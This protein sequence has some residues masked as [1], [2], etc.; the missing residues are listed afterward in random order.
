M[1]CV[2][3][4]VMPP[5][6]PRVTST[7]AVLKRPRTLAMVMMCPWFW[8]FIWGRKAF[9]VWDTHTHTHA[10]DYYEATAPL[11]DLWGLKRCSMRRELTLHER[12]RN[13]RIFAGILPTVVWRGSNILTQFVFTR[14]V[15]H[16]AQWPALC[17]CRCWKTG[18]KWWLSKRQSPSVLPDSRDGM[19][20]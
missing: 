16:C 14:R 15:S 4:A 19:F 7:Q 13:K 2:H 17:S 11:Y 20:R 9:T 6:P 1:W 12:L 3:G 10:S 8:A 5:T 18:E